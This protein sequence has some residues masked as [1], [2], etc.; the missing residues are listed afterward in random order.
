MLRILLKIFVVLLGLA[1]L[2]ALALVLVVD[3]EEYK[4]LL[5][6]AAS[7]ATG[8][9][10]RIEGE[11]NPRLLP[12]PHLVLNGV[13]AVEAGRE[14][15]RVGRA[16][17]HVAALPLLRLEARPHRVIVYDLRAS[18]ERPE[19]PPLELAVGECLFDAKHL[20]MPDEV[21]F[22]LD[23]LIILADLDC[24]DLRAGQLAIPSL[25]ATITG[26]RGLYEIQPV[27]MDLFG[28]T[29]R[30]DAEVDLTGDTV[31]VEAAYTLSEFRLAEFLQ[32]LSPGIAA[33]G[34]LDFSLDVAMQGDPGALAESA[35][36]MVSLRGSELVLEGM[37]I[38]SELE[39]FESSQ[40]FNLV[41]AGAFMFAGP[42]GL[43]VTKGRDFSRLLQG[44]GGRTHIREIVSDWTVER[45]I[46][47]AQD[48]AFAT[49]ENLLAMHGELDFV[50]ERFRG[51]EV[52]VLD[53]QGCAMVRQEITGAFSAPEVRQPSVLEALTGPVRNLFDRFR[54]RECEVFYTGSVGHPAA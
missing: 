47:R 1:L 24:G 53:P 19:A 29:G 12:R 35:R 26:T 31:R 18:L 42:V 22:N 10:I 40:R 4:P 50:H 39:D 16:D 5:E 33:E 21:R 37:D 17:I 52:A 7:D 2:A 27:V 48:V 3:G 25:Q 14:L 28:G 44:S 8:Y 20:R 32:A 9:E 49:G 54:N 43:A 30:G 11:V 6:Q 41:D 15:L 36:G 45:G 13:V 34:V 23:E 38:D 46:A 51:V